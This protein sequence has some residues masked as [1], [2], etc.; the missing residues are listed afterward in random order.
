MDFIESR[1]STSIIN[2]IHG[3]S[4][5]HYGFVDCDHAVFKIFNYK[6]GLANYNNDILKF[7]ELIDIDGNIYNRID[8]WLK[9]T[10]KNIY[11]PIRL[12]TKCARH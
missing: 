2:N 4:C 10:C 7:W 11:K 5:G 8:S 1:I 12:L 9:Y 3:Y 6:F